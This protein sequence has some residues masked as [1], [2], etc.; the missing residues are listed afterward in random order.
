MMRQ[1]PLGRAG[2]R[3]VAFLAAAAGGLLGSGVSGCD[4][5][6]T[7]AERAAA[8]VVASSEQS[9]TVSSAPVPSAVPVASATGSTPALASAAVDSGPAVIDLERGALLRETARGE[10][11]DRVVLRTPGGLVSCAPYRCRAGRCLLRCK[12]RKDCAGAEGPREMAE[13]GWPLDCSR[14]DGTCY[15]LPPEHV[16]GD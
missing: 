10:C 14:S 11:S 2:K 12:T 16:T 9:A 6:A 5:G 15:P 13:H 7:P 8:S 1:Q 3:G 4:R